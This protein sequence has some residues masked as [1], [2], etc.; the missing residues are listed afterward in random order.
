MYTA[1]PLAAL[2][3]PFKPNEHRA[4]AIGILTRAKTTA[5]QEWYVHSI[6]EDIE[7]S[8]RCLLMMEE[9]HATTVQ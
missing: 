6:L 5:R 8:A 3:H 4:S 2:A 9:V 7:T 1:C